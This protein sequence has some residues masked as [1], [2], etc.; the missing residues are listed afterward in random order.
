MRRAQ[1]VDVA[2]IGAVGEG[3]GIAASQ[4]RADHGGADA[5]PAADHQGAAGHQPGEAATTRQT[6]WPPK[7]KELEIARCTRASRATL[8]TQS[9]GSA[10][11][12]VA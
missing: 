2:G 7:P 10:G 1:R 4:Q 12:G 5:A 6:F 3:H 11:S 9:T 8:G